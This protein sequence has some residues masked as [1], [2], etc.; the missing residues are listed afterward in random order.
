MLTLTRLF[1]FLAAFAVAAAAAAQVAVTGTVLDPSGAAIP[2]AAVALRAKGATV[3]STVTDAAG[4][5]RID[6]AAGRYEIDVKAGDAF[7]PL[8][9]A[10][11]V[12]AGLPPL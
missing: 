10:V 8:R 3:A 11:N 4:R 6:A 5:F 9:R 1:A 12:A 2:G 7:A